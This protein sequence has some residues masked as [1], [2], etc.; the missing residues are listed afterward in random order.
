MAASGAE[1]SAM[2]KVRRTEAAATLRVTAGSG[3][4]ARVA[5][6]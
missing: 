1:A 4:P 3:T 5:T 6:F 2:A